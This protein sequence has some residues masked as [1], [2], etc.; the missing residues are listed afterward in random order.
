MSQQTLAPESERIQP[1]PI[2]VTPPPKIQRLERRLTLL[3]TI[4]PF[5]GAAV[6]I[7][8]IWG[9]GIGGFDLGLFFVMYCISGL[10]VT[11]GFHRLLTHKSFDAGPKTRAA[12]ALAGSLAVQGP[13]IRW[14]ADHRRHHAFTDKPGDPHSPHLAE[15][16]GV[17]GVFA[18][19]WHSHMGWLFDKEMTSVPR[20][21]PDLLKEPL[22]RKVDKLFPLW[23]VV[24]FLAP[25]VAGLLYAGTLRGAFTAFIWGGLVRMFFLHHVTWSI[26]SIC[27]FYG[28]RPFE[29]ED[30]STNNWIMSLVSFGEG[31]HNTHH[32]FPTSAKHGL[33]WWQFDPT[34]TVIWLMVKVGLAHNL[35]VPSPKQVE[36]K[37]A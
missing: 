12:L 8:L 21:A 22:M 36:A 14:V 32:A 23:I 30:F 5:L 34:A 37:R 6:G 7:P 24:S 26:N 29:N 13:V 1:R 3:V 16:E 2:T 19:L 27:H 35:R 31:W 10:G 20:F 9:N 17:K 25:A 15:T 4:L 33:E 11:V 18:G 28:R